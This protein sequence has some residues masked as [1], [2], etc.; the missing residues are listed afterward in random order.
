ML[1]SPAMSSLLSHSLPS[2]AG[3]SGRFHV[4]DAWGHAPSGYVVTVV[5]GELTG[6]T[7]PNSP[8]LAFALESFPG[9]MAR[10]FG[11]LQSLAACCYEPRGAG[12]ED[13]L[14]L[15]LRHS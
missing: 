7:C 3:L 4:S 2:L 5:N 10:G 6:A 14:G 15:G 12:N 11:L 1:Y 8:G 9:Y 13:A